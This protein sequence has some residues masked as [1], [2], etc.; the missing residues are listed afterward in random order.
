MPSRRSSRPPCFAAHAQQIA[1]AFERE[2]RGLNAKRH[3]SG[4]TIVDGSHARGAQ[5]E[6]G[7]LF[8][9]RLQEES[10]ASGYLALR[11]FLRAYDLVGVDSSGNLAVRLFCEAEQSAGVVARIEALMRCEISVGVIAKAA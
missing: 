10:M 3:E 9:V 8:R 11:R 2:H 1:G 7:Y 6:S 5:G 4:L